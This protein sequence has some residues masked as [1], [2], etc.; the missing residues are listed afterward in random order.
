[1]SEKPADIDPDSDGMPTK[2]EIRA[3]EQLPSAPMSY[4]AQASTNVRQ[5]L[6]HSVSEDRRSFRRRKS[7][8]WLTRLIRRMRG[9][10]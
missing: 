8:S 9:T 3:Y 4:P 5:Y 2:S 7:E 1:M 6:R 10:R